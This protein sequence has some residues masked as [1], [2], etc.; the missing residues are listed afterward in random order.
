MARPTTKS[1]LLEHAQQNY[2][3]LL[4][5]VGG[6]PVEIRNSQFPSGTLNRNISDV[7]AHLHAWHLLFLDWYTIGMSGQKPKMP[8]KGYTWNTLPL[9]NIEIQKLYVQVKFED[10]KYFSVNLLKRCYKLSKCILKKIYLPKRNMV[11]QVLL[12]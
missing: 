12:R 4:E 9:L 1:E 10:S 3:R 5:L 8:A 7:L 2:K 11:G 6:F